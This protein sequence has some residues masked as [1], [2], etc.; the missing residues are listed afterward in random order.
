MG[1]IGIW[2]AGPLIV[3]SRDYEGKRA[4]MIK[5]ALKAAKR[6]ARKQRKKA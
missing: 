1:D 6:A 3:R 4:A 2:M 5:R